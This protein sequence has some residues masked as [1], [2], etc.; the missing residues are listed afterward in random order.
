MAAMAPVMAPEAVPP[1][2]AGDP[3]EL[4]RGSPERLRREGGAV[5]VQNSAQ[6]QWFS[7]VPA[8]RSVVRASQGMVATSQPLASQAGLDVLKRGGNAVDASIAMAAVLNVTEPNMT[9]VGGDAFMMIYPHVDRSDQDRL[10]RSQPVH[11]RPGVREGPGEDLV[12]RGHERILP[13][14]GLTHRALM[15]GGQAIMIDRQTGAL[16]GGSD[17]RKDGLALGW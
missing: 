10:R 4:R 5:Q 9:G 14:P 13:G 15:G 16:L 6:D 12:Q 8:G 7:S 2:L 3:S 17:S 1:P 11:C